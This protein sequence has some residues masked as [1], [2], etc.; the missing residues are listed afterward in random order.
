MTEQGAKL[1]AERNAGPASTPKTGCLTPL[2]GPLPAPGIGAPSLRLIALLALTIAALLAIA[3]AASAKQA[4]LFSASFGAATST[5]PNP[6]PIS[7]GARV[8]VDQAS[9][10][11][12]VTD[13]FANHNRVEKFDAAGNFLLM[14]GK[15]VNK[16][17]VEEREAGEPI[18]EAEEN[19][20][21]AASGDTCQPGTSSS[22]PGGFLGGFGV[23]LT[24]A[25]DNS[26]G[27]SKGDVY[28]SDAHDNLVSK[29]DPSGHLISSW[30]NNGPL[31]TPNGQLNGANATGAVHGPFGEIE[32][33]A[34]D[35]TGN[36][37][38]FARQGV[39]RQMFEFR[40]DGTF[41]TG[42]PASFNSLG[43]PP[44]IAVD[45]EDNLYV[46][47]RLEKF[48]TTGTDLGHVLEPTAHATA[49]TVDPTSGELYAGVGFE[50]GS[51]KS[52]LIYRFDSGCQPLPGNNAP[53]CT[54]AESLGAGLLGNQASG[55]ALD[56]ST[57][58]APLYAAVQ[59]EGIAPHVL[60]FARVTVPDTTTAKASGF[61][62]TT[63][64]LNGIVEPEGVPTTH[65]FFEWG[66]TTA[67]GNKAPCSQGEVLTG[68]GEDQVSAE[69]TGLTPGV[70]YHFRLVAANAN[71]DTAA[72]PS[73]GDDLAFG[74]PLIEGTAATAVAATSAD[75]QATLNPQNV[76]TQVR[77]EYG[78]EAGV[79]DHATPET[80][81]GSA[82]TPQSAPFHLTGLAPH[83]TYHYRAVAESVL[84]EGPEAV[85]GPD[86]A[87]TTQTPGPFTL[88][89]HR[90]WELVSPPDKRGAKLLPIFEYGVAQAAA[91]GE[92]I[93]YLA[94]APTEAQPEGN[95]NKTQVLSA[96]GP[97]AAW[98]SRD[99]SAPHSATTGVGIGTGYEYK[100]FSAD[101]SHALL[102]PFGAFEPSLSPQATQQTPFLR[103]NF[104]AGEPG[105]LCTTSC[106]HPLLV[107]CPEAGQ[108]C[109]P[110]VE[111]AANVPAG[112]EFGEDRECTPAHSR[113]FQ[114]PLC[115]P[116]FVGAGPDLAHV[117]LASVI[118]LAE[119]APA[120]H[121]TN[122]D[123]P[124]AL[125]LWSLDSPPSEQLQLL[126]V[127]PN[128]VPA[129]ISA[130]AGLGS[131]SHSRSA[132]RNAISADGSRVIF[133]E[134][135]GNHHLYLRYNADLPQSAIEAGGC[136]EPELA[137]TLQLDL[138]QG[139][140]GAG[141]VDPVFQTAS[142]DGSRIFFTD[143]QA[144]TAGSGAAERQPDLYECR[145]VEAEEGEL[146]CELT[147]LT[148]LTGGE[149][150]AVLG[151]VP[152]A[153]EDGSY[154][155]F[156]A[157]GVLTNAA[158]P[159]GE[160]ASPGT[161]AGGGEPTG[162]CNLY[163]SHAGQTTFIATLSGGDL[164]DWNPVLAGN[165]SRISADGRW[166]A[167]MSQR[168]LTGYDNRD[169]TTGEPDQQVY[170]YHAPAAGGEAGSLICASCNPT[171]AR[172][173]GVKY[174]GNQLV[175]GNL[176]FKTPVAAS[177][178][179]WIRVSLS[180]GSRYQPRYLS[181]SG[182]LF[183][184][185]S[186]AIVPSDANGTEDVYQYEPPGVGNCTEARPT[187]SPAS[188]GCIDLISS[189][190][191]AEESAFLD[192]S[193]TGED[194]FFLTSGQLSRRDVDT[195]PDVYDA[196]V[197]GGEPEPVKPV[198][199][200][201]DGCQQ[202]AVPPIHPTPGT[203]L[204]DG[205]GNLLQCPKGRVKRSGK[206]VAKKHAKKH[207]KQHHK[208]SHKRASTNRRAGK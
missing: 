35:P 175:S 28:L 155:Y 143:T 101:L 74:P 135:Q 93:S 8:A 46:G 68:S 117:V 84:G 127:R 7:I 108:P 119:G 187:Y 59:G 83:T 66:T 48:T 65:C 142:A 140:T 154:L 34:V 208:R 157:Q 131:E 160:T 25:V 177:V 173:H 89:D 167:F 111:A 64:T 81:L 30:G 129:P 141:P 18:T 23:G 137:C 123:V 42:W 91:S 178:P 102:H 26:T 51:G 67:Y 153:S 37:W 184:N 2:S 72:E 52:P 27:P 150:A 166:L 146:K 47:D 179:G 164:S 78:T 87:F 191:S 200:E 3:P 90:G 75:L 9:H 38:V 92:A 196:H 4:R 169:L 71:T 133:S 120:E 139:G 39:T 125:Y 118:P 198:E 136:S 80:D 186:D 53:G 56:P 172:P 197:N 29:F 20:C 176:G 106:Y 206:C 31:E 105:A 50:G 10:D 100:F 96:R 193:E 77:I 40:Q 98:A 144:L 57:A 152:G 194:V 159:L 158:N 107:A 86:R 97:A 22:S 199:C 145:I 182:R 203:A 5:V 171:G 19:L 205:P 185:S 99:I 181:D 14:F 45:A 69:I 130:Q 21:T 156:V 204:L 170:L 6:Y 62:A 114:S 24:V 122:P 17:K 63:A 132:A 110:A 121:T 183:F 104:P 15:E 70:T 113:P 165:T 147:D 109:P 33:L 162:T 61:T 41:L 49:L 36:L 138:N 82:G 13:G 95:A 201:G 174:N 12:Y 168:S 60:A 32:G 148:P 128:G 161:C 188:L 103:T 195:A 85:L 124:F 149:S 16:T 115:G 202:P 1:S 76:D 58:A 88:P 134:G 94:T 189:G 163:L 43:E 151:A 112:T 180:I 116:V 11:V 44:G 73:L 54:P 192:A 79:Y 126:S 207:R 55:L 190:E